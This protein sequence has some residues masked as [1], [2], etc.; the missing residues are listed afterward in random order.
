MNI[1]WLTREFISYKSIFYHEVQK[2]ENLFPP[3]IQ[4]IV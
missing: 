3:K 2:I 4:E 1:S